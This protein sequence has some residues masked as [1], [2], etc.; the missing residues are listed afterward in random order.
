MPL[1]SC[2]ARHS[3]GFLCSSW[4]DAVVPMATMSTFPHLMRLT[5]NAGVEN[6][7]RTKAGLENAG[8]S[9]P[10][11]SSDIFAPAFSAYPFNVTF[12][13][14]QN[15]GIKETPK[16]TSCTSCS[17]KRMFCQLFYSFNL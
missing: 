13:K 14:R 9:T 4:H 8:V 5:E 15:P 10:A 12:P 7:G 3:K 11:D 1:F 6:E 16:C 2:T 17:E